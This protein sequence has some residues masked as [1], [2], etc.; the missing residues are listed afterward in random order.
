[1][2]R[3]FRPVSLSEDMSTNFKVTAQAEFVHACN[4]T[5]KCCQLQ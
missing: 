1:M 3:V 2:K 5:G 4:D